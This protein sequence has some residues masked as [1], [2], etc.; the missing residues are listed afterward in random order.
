M[1]HSVVL[2]S[3]KGIGLC[4]T[5]K[6]LDEGHIV[7]GVSRSKQ[8]S[9]NKNFLH[10][11]LDISDEKALNQFFDKVELE[12]FDNIVISAGTNDIA[13]LK[14]ITIE[15][16]QKL[17]KL[18]V[19]PAFNLL[20]KISFYNENKPRSIVFLTSIWSNTGIKGR[21]MYGSSK[22]ALVSL[23]KHASAE[24]SEKSFFINCI[25]PGFTKTEL[26]DKSKN[27]PLIQKSLLRT[28]KNQMQNTNAVSEAIMMLLIPYNHGITGQEIFV[29]SGFSS[30]A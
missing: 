21:A 19:Y 24:L 28:S 22:A 10:Y 7:V 27:D 6:L 12:K 15:R 4:I 14:E 16:L 23:S 30:H 20:K 13:T 3:S 5:N 8:K 2:G 26:S 17:Y 18:N 29:D 25:S 9:T 11:Q 1:I